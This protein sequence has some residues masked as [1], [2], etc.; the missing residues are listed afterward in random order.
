MRFLN[1][2]QTRI[3]A[4]FVL[5]LLAV[6]LMSFW[7][8]YQS[9]QQLE[10]QHVSNQLAVAGLVFESQFNNRNNYLAA[11][12][13]TAA[14]DFGLKEIFIDGDNR[15]FLVALNNHRK[16]I[17]ASLAIAVSGEGKVIGQ[18]VAKK[19]D[20]GKE[21]VE[22]GSEQGKDFRYQLDSEFQQL[23]P[24]YLLDGKL[25][26]IKFS[27][28]T[29]GGSSV[30]GWVGFG[31]II[32]DVL[33]NSLR[34][35]T[36]LDSGFM[37]NADSKMKDIGHSGSAL[38]LTEQSVLAQFI[39]KDQRNS[40]YILWQQSLGDVQ[41]ASLHAYMY[42]SRSDLLAALQSQWL[43]QI[44]LLLLMVPFSLLLAF[45]ISGSITRP[46]K[47]LIEQA[48]FIA[49]GNY[50][51]QVTVDSSVE[52]TQLASEFTV[53]Q[54]A[55]LKREGEIAHQAFHDPLT[56]LP[57]LNELKRVSATWFMS[58][59][60]MAIC[61][62]NIRRLTDV[63]VTLGHAVGDDVIKEVARRLC[64]MSPKALVCRLSGDEFVLAF[65]SCEQHSFE[66]F[67][68]QL[69]QQIGQPYQFQDVIL[70]L[71]FTAGVSFYKQDASL[72]TLLRHADTALQYAKK[73]K[74]DYQIYD[75]NI[76]KN[77]LERFQLINELKSAIEQNELVLFYQ[78]KLH[79]ASQKVTHV[80][81]LVRWMHPQ[82]G[83][84][85]PDTFIPIAEKTM[86]MNS[87]TRWVINEAIAQYL[88]WQQM[89]IEICIAVNISAENLKDEQFCHW[90]INVLAKNNVP[91]SAMTLEITEDAV[92]SDPEQ[93]VKQ[94]NMLR[95][96]GLKLS[97]DDYGTG[98]SSL[99]QLKQLPVDELKIDKSFVLK[100]MQDESDQI[101]VR[102]TLQLAHSLGLTVVA[103]GI[104]D[105][106][107][108]D[109]LTELKCEMGQGFYLSRPLPA[110]QFN[111]WLMA[112][113]YQKETSD[114]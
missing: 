77:T 81:A 72:V 12:A 96:N 30:I 37:L 102:S 71:Q 64:V 112:S 50:D 38:T 98:Y 84:I 22:L 100:L 7:L 87:L 9:N 79:L 56:N 41:G 59:S 103:E 85:P 99:A 69:Q 65:E 46:I 31:F 1:R 52:L 109:W 39:E 76:D 32:D 88:R 91:V 6:Q 27:V 89:D 101:I 43:Q 5:L 28:L 20:L 42:K 92:V 55:I 15:S 110:E 113:P 34:Q 105:K 97:I 35:L 3:F 107:T 83:L 68:N 78:P 104:E 48:K 66:M 93:A 40:D 33:A 67:L 73:N 63:N 24:F 44:G 75:A 17:D 47:Q 4:F 23:S 114:H 61:L 111:Q 62:I 108:L 54:Q 51:S 106:L 29:S 74:L 80:E 90:V 19:N 14:K 21:Q 58:H 86:Q 10:D 57:N 2:L 16:R 25:Y 70:S 11:F 49:K 8:T 13:E 36:G 26:Q 94:L 53:M 95:E 82:K 18:L 45:V 60:T